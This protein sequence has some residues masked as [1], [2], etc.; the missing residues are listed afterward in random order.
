MINKRRETKKNFL[1][2]F[3][4]PKYFKSLLVFE[5]MACCHSLAMAKGKL[6]G[7]PLEIKL[8]EASDCEISDGN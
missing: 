6:I 3:L 2:Y 8:F 1:Q 4:L 5:V 7:D